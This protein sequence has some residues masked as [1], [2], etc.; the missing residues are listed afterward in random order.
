M[1]KNVQWSKILE[2]DVTE[3]VDYIKLAEAYGIEGYKINTLDELIET[4]NFIDFKNKP[5]FIQ[6]NINKDES[7]YPIVPPGQPIDQMLF[8]G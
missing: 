7:V 6:C 1:A 3:D 8:E 5:I 4:L 2:T